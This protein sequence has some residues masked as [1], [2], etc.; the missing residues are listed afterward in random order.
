M[1]TRTWAR[2][3]LDRCFSPAATKRRRAVPLRLGTLEERLVPATFRWVN[4]AGG[5]FATAANWEDQAGNAGVPGA[6]D[7]AIILTNGVTVT[8]TSANAVHNLTS[9]ATLSITAG[10]LTAAAANLIGPTDIAGG[11]LIL[12]GVG[13][14]SSLSL[15]AGSL[16]GAGRVDVAS[17]MIWTG[18]TV[19]ADVHVAGTATLDMSGA[20]LKAL[21]NATLTNDGTATWAGAGGI[22]FRHNAAMVNDGIFHDQADHAV[23]FTGSAGEAA[24]WY[25]PGQYIKEAGAGITDIGISFNNTGT[26]EADS[27]TL[28]LSGTTVQIN[29]SSQLTAGSW[30][31]GA[32]ATLDVPG[33]SV[34]TNQA[35]ITL[36]GAGASFT[37]MSGMTG[38][39]GSLTLTDGANFTDPVT[40]INLGQ[41]T[42]GPAS[43]L[44]V[45][46]L[47]QNAGTIK[48]EV[49]GRPASNQF[50]RIINSSGMS[51]SLGT[52]DV[53]MLPGADTLASDSYTLISAPSISGTF[54]LIQQEGAGAT[55]PF[56]VVTTATTVTATANADVTNLAVSG[57]IAPLASAGP[58]NMVTVTW[59]TTNTSAVATTATSWTDSV[60]ISTSPTF[61]STAVLLGRSIHS[62]ALAGSSSYP[63][64]FTGPLPGVAA[65]NYYVFVRVDA[66]GAVADVDRADNFAVAGSTFS[67]TE[68][69]SI[70]LGTPTNGTITAGQNLWYRVAAP[71]GTG[72]QL[73]AV[74]AA[75]GSGE[76][77]VDYQK[78]PQVDS[79]LGQ[80][81]DASKAT[82]TVILPTTQGGNYYLH[83]RG[84]AGAGAGQS[85]T[86]QADTLDFAITSLVNARGSNQGTATLTVHGVGF[87]PNTKVTLFP[88]GGGTPRAPTTLLYVQSDTIYATFNLKG[89]VAGSYDVRVDDGTLADTKASGY[90]VTNQ[91]AGILS[92]RLVQPDNVKQGQAGLA[93]IDFINNGGTDIPSPLLLLSATNGAAQ[94]RLPEQS[95]FTSNGLYVLLTS[96]D[97]P[98]GIIP[99]GYQGSMQVAFLPQVS[100]GQTVNLQ[101]EEV[102]SGKP[103][104]WSIF[105]NYLRPTAI[106]LDAWNGIY[107]NFIAMVG[108]T[109]DSYFT[110]L[111]NAA[112]YL[113]TVG[114]PERDASVLLAY[115]IQLADAP[116]P[117]PVFTSAIDASFPSAGLS[118]VFQRDFLETVHG[119]YRVG[120]LGRG[121]VD[122][123]DISISEFNQN[124][125]IH[126]GDTDFEFIPAG[127]NTFKTSD[128][129]R[130]LLVQQGSQFIWTDDNGQIT[131]F[132]SDGQLDYLEAPNGTRITAGYDVQNHLISLTHSDGRALTFTWNK[133]GQFASVT[134][135][136]GRATKLTFGGGLLKSATDASG[137]TKYAYLGGSP[138]QKYAMASI[139]LPGNVK[140]T[141]TYDKLGRLI[142]RKVGKLQSATYTYFPGGGSKM[143]DAFGAST[144]ILTDIDGQVAAIRDGAGGGIQIRYHNQLPVR[145]EMST[146]QIL[147]YTRDSDER[148][149]AI[150]DPL[151]KVIR[152]GYLDGSDIPISS[153][154]ANGYTTSMVLDPSS[155]PLA[156][157]NPASAT[158]TFVY[159]PTGKLVNTTNRRGKPVSFLR[160]Q[161]G[162]ITR[163]VYSDATYSNFTYD[164]QGN[165]LT[166]TNVAGTI[167]LTYFP[168]DLLQKI[169]YPDGKFLEFTYDLGGRRT[170]SVDQDGFTSRYTYDAAGRLT[171]VLDGKNIKLVKYTYDLAG[172]LT[173]KDDANGTFATYSFDSLGRLQTIANHA[174]G[175]TVNSQFDYAYDQSGQLSSMTTGGL[176]TTCTYDLTGQ[177]LSATTPTRMLT[178]T[179]DANG[180]RTSVT[181]NGVT[182]T[183]VVNPLNETTAIGSTTF[184][185]DADGNRIS[186]TDAGGTT[187]YTWND[188]SELT[189]VTSLTD[190]FVYTRDALDQLL[191][192]THNGQTTTNLNDPVGLGSIAAQYDGTNLIA[193]YLQG[194]GLEARADSTGSFNY[195]DFDRLGSVVGLTN[196]TGSYVNQY[197]Y[198][199]FGETATL[200]AGVANPFT[201]VGKSNVTADGNGLFRMKARY[202]DAVGGA[203]VSNDPIGTRG[204]DAN[205]RRYVHNNPLMIAD[206][207]G[208]APASNPDP[209]Y[210]V[211]DPNAEPDEPEPFSGDAPYDP[212]SDIDQ[213]LQQAK[214]DYHDDYRTANS[215]F[216]LIFP[217][218]AQELADGLPDK[219]KEI[220]DLQATKDNCTERENPKKTDPNKNN[221]SVDQKFSSSPKDKIAGVKGTPRTATQ[222]TKVGNSPNRQNGPAGK[223]GNGGPVGKSRDDGRRSWN[224]AGTTQ[225]GYSIDFQ[226]PSTDLPVHTVH[227][228]EQ[229]DPGFDPAT[230]EIGELDLGSLTIAVPAGRTS[231]HTRVDA[232]ETWGVFV[233]VTAG[234]D[235]STGLATWDLIALD[236][237]TLEVPLD[238]TIGI[239]PPTTAG[240]NGTVYYSVGASS[241]LPDGSTLSAAAT[242]TFGGSMPITTATISNVVDSAPPTATVNPLPAKSPAKFAVS[243]TGSDTAGIAFYDIYVS[244]DGGSFALWVAGTTDTSATY[245]GK[246]K[247]TYGFAAVA[248]DNLGN[249]LPPPTVAQATTQ[250]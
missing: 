188:H 77:Y 201:F 58:G 141:F 189:G 184:G 214:D 208:L 159:D 238:P 41:L 84:L 197:S 81:T 185:Y 162:Q 181:D 127:N 2:W 42:V 57:V 142:G 110:A 65:G 113:A 118:L 177:L 137:T 205:L 165:L 248:Y 79:A 43:T 56:N 196:A 100:T 247:H 166:A 194:I 25:N 115:L 121:W 222:P 45:A 68:P 215:F 76:L 157:T 249:A 140:T 4:P 170:S 97:A 88:S 23:T 175:G 101:I 80:A 236:P 244:I 156:I 212:C 111:R 49:A 182:T 128:G 124:E 240:M 193:N 12:G 72:L 129:D 245:K 131:A 83:V 123:W 148:I 73:S 63:G 180:N 153:T 227:I 250:V 33:Q 24:V 206:P 30:V 102:N 47:F 152:Y 11:D 16:G 223:G 221:K 242:T 94:L 144:T 103:L 158:S 164:P 106:P 21:D 191:T 204:G 134:D 112:T 217:G 216:R 160:N 187:N 78:L 35:S 44:N 176:T 246:A 139:T 224:S 91:P 210:P 119:R 53:A 34:F 203:F 219:Q 241:S 31:I 114:T 5:D 183:Y 89:L 207:S 133:T 62:G 74:F 55:S 155:N 146:G 167:T 120:R 228:A 51:I 37:P 108:K 15:S 218:V 1:P 149:T 239:L 40:F 151:G 8:S 17:G 27:G 229:L 6:T 66:D 36:A 64:S 199:P 71:G 29:A 132:R 99:A 178:Y 122:N 22:E 82:E 190:T 135:S 93:T 75:P 13:T 10:T 145:F 3:G 109:S 95:T 220:D 173:R 138:G 237:A 126:V 14:A 86:I 32:G 92:Y 143:A 198:L 46:S 154:D 243:W 230:F 202:F 186:M 107:A 96:T 38:N 19:A 39:I 59:T 136:V 172:R 26:L 60:Y 169:A 69:P 125:I 163:I 209:N 226:N 104:D 20:T 211:I 52:L 231:Y 150:T 179:Y 48:I 171:A 130:G 161:D 233:D 67:V 213:R 28:K 195:Y 98:A 235:L 168:N 85:F 9:T 117:S 234:L 54:D 147:T 105:K 174:P 7:D 90:A 192:T 50:G 225:L 200:A 232:R 87:T 61:D 70:A 116:Q 18:G